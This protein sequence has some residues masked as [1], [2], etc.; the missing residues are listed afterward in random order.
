MRYRWLSVCLLLSACEQLAVSE[1]EQAVTGGGDFSPASYGALPDDGVDDRTGLQATL[2]S[3]CDAGGGIVHLAAGL[4]EIGPNALPG[5]VN[6]ESLS[7]RCSNV[8]ITGEGIS[9]VLQATGDGGGGDWNLLQVRAAPGSTAP[10]RNIEID[11]L[12][13][14][15][16]GMWNTEEQTHLLQIGVGPV[17]GVSLHHLWFYYPS[18]QKSDGSGA[19]RGGDCIRMIGGVGKTVRFTQITDSQ[20]LDCDRSAIGFQREV[21][22]TIIDSNMFLNVGDQHIDQEPTGTGSIGRFVITNNLFLFGSQGSHAITLTGNAI[23]EPASE[24][25]FSHNVVFGRGISL[26]NVQRAVISDNVI[27]GK[28]GNGEA[29]VFARKS[30]SD[31]LLRGNYIERLPGSA[32]GPVISVVPHNSGYPSRWKIDGNRIVSSVDGFELNVES[33]SNVSIV[34][35]DFEFSGPTA[36]TYA[37]IRLMALQSPL[38]NALVLGNRSV[39]PLGGFLL[40]SPTPYAIGAVSVVGNMSHGA[41][42]GIL[43]KT[44][45]FTKPVVHSGYYYDGATTAS[46]CPANLKLV[47]QYP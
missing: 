22:D 14:S 46:K 26:Y 19:E 34:N 44:G 37:A 47:A 1:T 11:N 21:Y 32:V 6:I 40:L 43:C 3:A 28:I 31:I 42:T 7:I 13:L 39:G 10:V 35:N 18:R 8:R 27:M 17:E 23:T 12:M 30:N 38:E 15:G 41:T 5:T 33:A 16:A 24:L 29:V 20:F 45:P 2:A 25:V 36:N 9:T 4:Y